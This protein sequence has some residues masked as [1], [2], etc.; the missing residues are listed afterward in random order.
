MQESAVVDYDR[1]Q[2][3]GDA[4]LM[5]TQQ[6]RERGYTCYFPTRPH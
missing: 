6:K 3:K 4:G 1:T 5:H 2:P